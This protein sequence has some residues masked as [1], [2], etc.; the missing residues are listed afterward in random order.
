[1]LKDKPILYI[2]RY[3]K[4]TK[5]PSSTSSSEEEF[6][7]IYDKGIDEKAKQFARMNYRKGGYDHV[8]CSALTQILQ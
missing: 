6:R 8:V 3:T 2:S 1:M 7:Q 5:K 4:F